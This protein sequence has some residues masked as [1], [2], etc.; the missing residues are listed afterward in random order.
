[1]EEVGVCF[2]DE[3][4]VCF[5]DDCGMCL[6]MKKVVFGDF[7]LMRRKKNSSC[8]ILAQAISCSRS[9]ACAW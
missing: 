5:D 7:F 6:M 2:D 9:I 8:T 4:G 3:C 1:M